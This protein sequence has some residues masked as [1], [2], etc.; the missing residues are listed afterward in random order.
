MSEL[1]ARKYMSIHNLREEIRRDMEDYKLL[2]T[3][4]N[5]EP[6]HE[7]YH[8]FTPHEEGITRWFTEYLNKQITI[9]LIKLQELVE[10]NND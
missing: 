2:W 5:L 7:I 3:T 9:N 8:L 4:I 10:Q 1:K 6:N